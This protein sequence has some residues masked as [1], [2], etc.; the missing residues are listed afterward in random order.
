[1]R[2]KNPQGDR[3]A[4]VVIVTGGSRGIGLATARAFLEQGARVGICGFDPERL[5]EAHKALEGLGEVETVVADVRFIGQIQAFVDRVI[6]R[7]ETADVLVNNAG[8]AS[9]GR[10]AE[11]EPGS[12][13]SVVDVNVKGVLYATRVVLPHMLRQGRGVIINVSSGAGLTGFP[14]IV[15]YCASKF[16][17]VGFTEALAQ[18]LR[19]TGVQVYGLCPGRVAT[20]MQQQYSGR[21]IGM[22][23]ERVAEAILQ[24]AG[25]CPPVASGCCMPLPG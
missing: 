20:D 9:V 10:F 16:A 19:G 2:F 24:L 17:V 21:K 11:E 22:P 13:D 1:M 18:E 3:A 23:P 7:F 12:I 25:R 14:E 5:L 4:Q 6:D 15:T 8:R